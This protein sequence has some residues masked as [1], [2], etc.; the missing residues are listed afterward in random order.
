MYTKPRQSSRRGVAIVLVLVMICVAVIMGAG[1][2]FFSVSTGQQVTRASMATAAEYICE[3]ACE[4]G[5]YLAQQAMNDPDFPDADFRQ[6]YEFVRNPQE[7][8]ITIEFQPTLL[9]KHIQEDY[10][11]NI[12]ADFPTDSVR[13]SVEAKLE[14]PF[15]PLCPEEFQGVLTFRAS[16]EPRWGGIRSG[17]RAVVIRRGFKV[18]LLTPP[19]PFDKSALTL[20]H[21]DYINGESKQAMDSQIFEPT[22]QGINQHNMLCRTF[23]MTVRKIK[24]S[25]C[26]RCTGCAGMSNIQTFIAPRIPGSAKVPPDFWYYDS[27]VMGSPDREEFGDLSGFNYEDFLREKWPPLFKIFQAQL[28]ASTAMNITL[29][30]TGMM[31][32]ASLH[33]PETTAMKAIPYTAAAGAAAEAYHRILEQIVNATALFSQILL[34]AQ[35]LTMEGFIVGSLFHAID[36]AAQGNFRPIAGEASTFAMDYYTSGAYDQVEATSQASEGVAGAGAAAE[37][38]QG[39]AGEGAQG[40]AGEGAAAVT[41]ESAQDAATQKDWLEFEVDAKDVARGMDVGGDVLTNFYGGGATS[42]VGPLAEMG[43][44][45]DM[46]A[47]TGLIKGFVLSHRSFYTLELPAGSA[48]FQVARAKFSLYNPALWLKRSSFY[49]TAPDQV[50]E[51]FERY[52]NDGLCGVIYYDGMEPLTLGLSSFKGKCILFSR[53]PVTVDEITLEDDARDSMTLVSLDVITVPATEVQASLN[54]IGD[55]NSGLEIPGDGFKCSGNILIRRYGV[56]D[57]RDRKSNPRALKG[58][59]VLNPRLDQHDEA[60]EVKPSHRRVLVTPGILSQQVVMAE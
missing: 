39:A 21:P 53:G 42:K 44:D 14:Q 23:K 55:E 5:F 26:S 56:I 58:E 30:A 47:L 25:N 24:S 45:T 18:V 1:L 22:N 15:S 9:L 49:L 50:T 10:L 6:L 17:H 57:Q 29:A 35:K 13:A 34:A 52:K 16:V 12:A 59:L 40:A 60:G 7:D 4:E 36:Q 20:I 27:V 8:T 41:Q 37:G 33:E 51:L 19:S 46:S 48:G 3:S 32:T 38:A 11:E 54:C 43:S 31:L 28:I 2:Y